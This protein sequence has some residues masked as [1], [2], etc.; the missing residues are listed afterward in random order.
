MTYMKPELIELVAAAHAIQSGEPTDT[1]GG[2]KGT[3]KA[4]GI[5]GDNNPV[6]STSGAYEADE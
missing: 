4:E 5:P 1:S 2:D 3:H 6:S